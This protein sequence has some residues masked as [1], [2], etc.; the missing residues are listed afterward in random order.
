MDLDGKNYRIFANGLR[1]AVGIKWVNGQLV[2]TN[3]GADHLG[4]DRPDETFYRIK[5]QQNY[6]WPYCFQYQSRIYADDQFKQSSK[7]INC[8]TVPLATTTFAAHSAPLGLEFF[9]ANQSD[10]LKDSFLVALHGGSKKSLRRGYQVV[11]IKY[12]KPEVFINGFLQNGVIYGRPVDLLSFGNGF[13]LTD[14]HSGVIYYVSQKA[15]H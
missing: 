8:K 14:D 3:M 2:A 10:R 12:G 1:N 13:L 15:S 11:Q 5:P 7:K 9:D 6:G 4:D